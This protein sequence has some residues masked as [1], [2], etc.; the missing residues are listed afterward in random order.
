MLSE[1]KS[2]ASRPVA[3]A[4]GES[5]AVPLALASEARGTGCAA[6]SPCAGSATRLD[7]AAPAARRKYGFVTP[8]IVG[9]S[10][11]PSD[12]SCVTAALS[13]GAQVRQASQAAHRG[14]NIPGRGGARRVGMASM[15]RCS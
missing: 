15:P 14:D 4:T 6:S 10:A 7:D 9:L 1:R 12:A 5:R 13:P 2:L 8:T 3:L 11:A